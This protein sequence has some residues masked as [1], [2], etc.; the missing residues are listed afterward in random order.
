MGSFSPIHVIIL[1]I[2]L[3]A[4][5]FP[6]VKIVGRTGLNP[7]WSLCAFIP[8]VSVIFLWVFAFARWPN[9]SSEKTIG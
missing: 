7:W 6:V 9:V 4:F 2:I 3:V 1:L 8:L 5:G